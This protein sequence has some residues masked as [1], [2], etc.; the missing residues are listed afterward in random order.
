MATY[1]SILAW[2][3]PW[4]EEPGGYSPWGC[5]VRHDLVTKQQPKEDGMHTV[6]H[7]HNKCW[8]CLDFIITIANTKLFDWW[9]EIQPKLRQ[10]AGDQESGVLAARWGV[11]AGQGRGGGRRPLGE[12]ARVEGSPPPHP[13]H[14]HG[15]C[16]VDIT[17]SARSSLSIFQE[18]PGGS[19]KSVSQWTP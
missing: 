12:H 2:R 10:W 19:I 7:T 5:K 13:Q 14:S 18:S 6:K 16:N 17:S 11:S 9:L 4:T 8:Y 15:L 3:I 1:S